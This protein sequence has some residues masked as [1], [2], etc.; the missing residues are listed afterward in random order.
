MAMP[1]LK[2]ANKQHGLSLVIAIFILVILSLLGAAMINILSAGTESVAREVLSTRA[3]FAAESGAQRKLNEI[4]DPGGAV[5]P[6][7]CA[8]VSDTYTQVDLDGIQGC[9]TLEVVV[10]C[11]RAFVNDINYFTITSEASCGPADSPAVRRIQVQASD[12]I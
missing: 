3:L 12:A 6:D 4:F 7:L 2:S 9:S 5:Q 11:A 8:N 1:G 10:D